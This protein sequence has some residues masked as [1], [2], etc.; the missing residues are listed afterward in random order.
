MY[1]TLELSFGK[2]QLGLLL[3]VRFVWF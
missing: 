2:K 3:G 1:I